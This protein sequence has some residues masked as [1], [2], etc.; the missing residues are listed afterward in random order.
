MGALLTLATTLELVA[1]ACGLYTARPMDHASP[2]Q[3]ALHSFLANALPGRRFDVV[4]ASVDASFRSYWRVRAGDASWVAMDAPPEHEDCRPW[5]DVCRRLRKAGLHAP[6]VLLEDLEQGF[7]LLEDLGDRIYL[8]ALDD[9]RVDR[10]YADALGALLTMQTRADAAELPAYDENRLRDEMELMP[11][12]FLTRHLRIT[13]EGEDRDVVETAFR[14]LL[15]NA[16]EQP[17]V[18]V[19]RDYHSR[20]LLITET[21]SPGIVDFQDAVIGPVSYDLVSLLRDCYIVW[22][23]ARVAAWAESHRRN[24]IETGMALP[25][26][27]TFRRWFDLMGLQR[28]IKVLGIF[29]RLCYRDGK[30][31]YLADL[32]RV[33]AYVDIVAARYSEFAA[34]R[35]LMR[36]WIGERDLTQAAS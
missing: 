28:H 17:T 21:N 34:F 32:P 14:H 22:P 29:C 1:R 20:N 9:T 4:P 15:E 33:W 18:F 19:H 3:A 36:R 30:A 8:P 26:A 12:W 35:A 31:G 2:R 5:L 16:L 11:T 13:P 6:E 23:E 25:D 7:L 10:L 27:D 24:L